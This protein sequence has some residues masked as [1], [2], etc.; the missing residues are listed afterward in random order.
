MLPFYGHLCTLSSLNRTSNVVK[1]KM[2]HPSD[3]ARS[4]FEP[5][6]SRSVAYNYN[7]QLWLEDAPQTCTSNSRY[8]IANKSIS[9]GFITDILSP[10]LLLKIDPINQ[11]SPKGFCCRLDPKDL[12]IVKDCQPEHLWNKTDFTMVT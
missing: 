5:R 4:E 8:F 11:T 3:I 9:P 12:K 1:W 10:S 6:C 7:N 2:K